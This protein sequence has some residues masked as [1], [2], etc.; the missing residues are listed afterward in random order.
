M[1]NQT[2]SLIDAVCVAQKI[3]AE[4]KELG[5]HVALAGSCLLKGT[6]SKDIDIH[7]YSH[8]QHQP[9]DKQRVLL[10]LEKLCV[11]D[12]GKKKF[13][14][15]NSKNTQSNKEFDKDVVLTKIDKFRIDL[16]FF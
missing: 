7:I 14:Q 13:Y 3:E 2:I 6:S 8:N 10:A 1:S 9:Y 4:V 12:E 16:F 5:A 11:A 15:C